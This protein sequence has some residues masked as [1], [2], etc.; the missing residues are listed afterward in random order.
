MTNIG[1]DGKSTVRLLCAEPQNY[2][3]R[4]LAI[5]AGLAQLDAQKLSQEEFENRAP[6]YDALLVRLQLRVTGRLMAACPRLRAII[7]PT[8]GLDHIDLESAR[9]RDIQVFSLRGETDFLVNI[10]STAEHTWA[11]LLC[12][13]RCIVPAQNSVKQNQWQQHH[14]RS[15]ELSGKTLGIVGLG[16]IGSMVARYGLGFG[17]QVLGYDPHKA[18][19]PEGVKRIDTL[20]QLFPG[21]NVVTVH[22]PLNDRTIGLIGEREISLLQKGSYLIN[23]SRGLIVDEQAI[24]LGLEQGRLAGAAVD[25]LTEEATVASGNHPMVAY[26]KEHDNLLITPHI[27]G[28][29]EDAIEKTDV[30]VMRRFKQWLDTR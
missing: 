12:L 11:L 23:T 28:A 30:F 16:R 4:G 5:A 13:M 8:T 27:G 18:S 10:T 9:N 21:S 2:S 6:S 3:L 15:R 7:S 17:M 25:V 24:L 26:A 14:L 19:F 29:A 1:S 22:V 20:D